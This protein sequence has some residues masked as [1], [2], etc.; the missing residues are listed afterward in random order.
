MH[1]KLLSLASLKVITPLLEEK[2]SLSVFGVAACP[3]GCWYT[4]VQGQLS[5][6]CG[7]IFVDASVPA[8]LF[9]GVHLLASLHHKKKK[10]DPPSLL[11]LTL[12]S[13]SLLL[14]QAT[15]STPLPLLSECASC[16]ISL[17][18]PPFLSPSLFLHQLSCPSSPP[19]PS[20]PCSH[21][22]HNTAI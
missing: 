13:Q 12:A 3:A 17:S 7:C 2:K 20:R 16:P 10:S 15:P 4:R 8:L 21:R 5:P 11:L 6:L 19:M 18:S 9:G 14:A 22:S 1:S